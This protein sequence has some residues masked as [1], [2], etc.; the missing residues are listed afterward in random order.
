[1]P[2]PL[3]TSPT[4]LRDKKIVT[5][6][7]WLLALFLVLVV[8]SW[9]PLVVIARARVTR[10][11]Q[12][13]IHLIQDMDKQPRYETQD[14]SLLF[15]DRRAMRPRIAGTVQRGSVLGDDHFTQ[16]FRIEGV[17]AESGRYQVTFFEQFPPQIA[18]EAVF[19]RQFLERGRNRFEIFCLPCHGADG[20]G[21]GSVNYHAEL[22]QQRA[23][24]GTSW[25]RPANL[26]D[27]A[28]AARPA[29]HIFNT[30]SKGIR[31]MPAHEAQIPDPY[32]RW[33]I[34][35]YVRALQLSQNAPNPAAAQASDAATVAT[36]N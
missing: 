5:P 10:S 16:G 29:G 2:E 11:P 1:M 18:N 23:D 25:V 34:V 35:A 4:P 30:I 36:G 33:A 12:P 20:A 15:A 6:P 8:V 19:T 21:N 28:I 3:T 27:A 32:D 17:D 9:V 26:T 22:L 7:F 31:T 24:T 13:R 14:H